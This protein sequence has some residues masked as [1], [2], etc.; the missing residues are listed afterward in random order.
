[1]TMGKTYVFCCYVLLVLWGASTSNGAEEE[2]AVGV[3]ELKRG[4]FTV[5]L[6]NFGATVLSVVLPDKNGK[7]DDVVLGFETIDEYKS[8]KTYFGNIVGRVANRIRGAQFTLNGKHYQLVPN[9]G[10][11]MLH[12][13]PKGFSEVVWKV[14]THKA[15]SHV[16]FTY[17]SF[18]GEQGFPGDLNVMVTYML[19]ETNKLGIKMEAKALNKATPVNLASHTYW[20][21]GGHG[22]GNILSHNLTLFAPDITPVDDELLPTGQIASVKGTAYD[23]RRSRP[24]GSMFNE[25]TDGY[26]I[27]YV[28]DTEGGN[29]HL[30]KVAVVKEG[31]SGRMMELWSNKPGV[32]FYTSNN[33]GH[34]KG[35]NGT[36]YSNYAGLCLE[37]QGFPD[38][39]NHPNF[40]SQIVN[41]G[42]TYKHVM[43]YRFTAN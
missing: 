40:P 9:E 34:L 12:G 33:L 42:E 19:I 43:V 5:K 36:T 37:T 38:S 14:K 10:D 32:Q 13:G 18:D 30:K 17:Q 39:V 26:D 16:T 41:P 6:T 28:V 31:K 15:D 21:L 25:L 8:D 29:K 27:N 20:N 7:L 22:S 24:I 1:M 11:N 35:K 4:D 23:F 2:E 3:Y